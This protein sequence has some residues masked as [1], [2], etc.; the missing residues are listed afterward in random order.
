MKLYQAECEAFNVPESGL[1]SFFD[2]V[3]ALLFDMDNTLYTNK[4][5]EKDQID[6]PVTRLAAILGKTFEQT[7]ADIAQIR[8]NYTDTHKGQ[9]ISLCNIFL[10]YGVS[11]E[12]SVKIR[13]EVL[14][15]ERYLKEDKKLELVLRKLSSRFSLAVVTNNPVSIA[16]RTLSLLGV[17]SL[18]RAIAGLDT[19]MVS[20]PDPAVYLKA[21][22]MCA[23][24]I[25]NCVSIGD[26]YSIDIKP[27]LE[28]GMKAILVDGVED[29]YKLA[30][31]SR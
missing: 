16:E 20:K 15:P 26:R 1:S 6:L 24:D 23:V 29:V 18:F 7:S 30:D 4:Q 3:Q 10:S 8:K 21:A 25:K 17:K 2:G 19:C 31:D 27:A 5:Y 12:E 22:K 28:I 14:K 9:T 11:V 13:E